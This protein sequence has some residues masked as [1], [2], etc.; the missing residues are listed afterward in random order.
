MS[1]RQDGLTN[2]SWN[3]TKF[4]SFLGDAFPYDTTNRFSSYDE[5]V[6]IPHKKRSWYFHRASKNLKNPT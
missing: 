2:P 6:D 5:S 4:F 3:I 1:I